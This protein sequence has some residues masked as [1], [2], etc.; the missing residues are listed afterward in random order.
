MFAGL[1]IVKAGL[2][3]IDNVPFYVSEPPHSGGIFLYVQTAIKI[4]CSHSIYWYIAV[5]HGYTHS[6][7][8]SPM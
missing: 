8:Y 5:K 2:L 4:I 1:N 7:R 3:T 6:R